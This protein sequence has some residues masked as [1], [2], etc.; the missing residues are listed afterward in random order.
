MRYLAPARFEDQ[1]VVTTR[2]GPAAGSRIEMAQEVLRDGLTL[3][4]CRVG[5]ACLGRG[6]RPVRVPAEVAAA[7]GTLPPLPDD[8]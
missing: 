4:K 1:L 8:V 7:L 5:L 2:A 3:A 6:G